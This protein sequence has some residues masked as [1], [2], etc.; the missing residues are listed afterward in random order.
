[1]SSLAQAIKP[2]RLQ[3]RPHEH[4]RD[5]RGSGRNARTEPFPGSVRQWIT[6]VK[7]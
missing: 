3:L 6:R 7:Q 2:H 1:M 5:P 4:G